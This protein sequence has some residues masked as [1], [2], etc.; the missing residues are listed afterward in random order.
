MWDILP[1]FQTWGGCKKK[2]SLGAKLDS[3]DN[4]D[5]YDWN[6]K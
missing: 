5:T 2:P 4:L 3:V 6:L 1:N